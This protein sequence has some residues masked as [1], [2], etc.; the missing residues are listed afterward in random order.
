MLSGS[1]YLLA[2]CVPRSVMLSHSKLPSPWQVNRGERVAEE[3]GWNFYVG[4]QCSDLEADAKVLLLYSLFFIC[5]VCLDYAEGERH[6]VQRP[7]FNKSVGATVIVKCAACLSIAGF[8]A[9]FF[10]NRL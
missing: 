1:L 6:F 5:P 2:T 4:F 10:P 3:S 9:A 7:F 8:S